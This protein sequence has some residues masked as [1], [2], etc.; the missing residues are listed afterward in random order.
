MV[1]SIDASNKI[2]P[3][4]L[5]LNFEIK[6]Y[7]Y[8]TWWFIV[9]IIVI[10]SGLFIGLIAYQFHKKRKRLT[11]ILE[12]NMLVQETEI[13]AIH[14][15][16][17][18]HFIF[19]SLHLINH[20]ISTKN[21]KKAEDL[22]INFSKLLRNVLEKSDQIFLPLSEELN[23]IKLYLNIQESRFNNQLKYT[24]NCD[25]ELNQIQIP[26]MI[27]QPIVENAI[28]HGI[29]HKIEGVGLISIRAIKEEGEIHIIIQD[30]GIGRKA[31][32]LINVTKS[33]RSAG[34]PL[35]QK[36]IDLLKIKYNVSVSYT[37]TD[38]NEKNNQTGTIVHLIIDYL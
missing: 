6:P 28:L 11:Q 20:L 30:N 22:L 37:I 23:F 25:P 34:Y 18:P 38:I 24:I 16:M 14:A 26:A 2:S 8:E 17:N 7:F 4:H 1:R 15:Q 31:S 13:K 21:Y 12:M 35:I 29:A 10:V 19:N 32:K 9:L 36:K 3:F 33:H 27:L 5:Q